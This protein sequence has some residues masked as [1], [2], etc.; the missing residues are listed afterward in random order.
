MNDFGVACVA[1]PERAQRSSRGVMSV[2]V[3]ETK[4]RAVFGEK[5]SRGR[6]KECDR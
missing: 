5:G 2:G 4:E 1:V 3:E 6:V